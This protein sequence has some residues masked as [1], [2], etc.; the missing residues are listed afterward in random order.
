MKRFRTDAAEGDVAT[1]T[2][3]TI[4]KDCRAILP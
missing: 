4:V 1:V 3:A 2:D